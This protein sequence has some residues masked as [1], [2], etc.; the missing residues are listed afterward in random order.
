M[1][2]NNK[3]QK[4]TGSSVPF[5]SIY[6]YAALLLIFIIAACNSSEEADAYGNFEAT[7]ITVSAEASGKIMSFE[8][9]EGMQLT[10]GRVVGFIDTMQLHLKKMQLLANKAA[11]ESGTMD[12]NAQIEAM[13]EQKKTL[14]SEL[15]R[16][17]R[18]LKDSAATAQ[19]L[20][21]L[22]GQIRVLDKQIAAI[23]I[24]NAPI[25]KQAEAL[26]AQIAQVD[27]M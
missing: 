26:E 10:A 18:L 1:M 8:A 9:E 27:D 12:V 19:Q 24:K 2:K 17:Q 15:Q 6:A 21:N 4:I 25:L 20:D 16:T 3:N 5:A 14:A 13:E 7:E 11:V 23:R 22:S